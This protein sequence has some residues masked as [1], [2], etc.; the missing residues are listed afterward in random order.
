MLKDIKTSGQNDLATR[1]D[2]LIS[3]IERLE[4]EIK[5]IQATEL[6]APPGC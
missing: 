6:A 2:Q 1:T 4:K 5:V 3:T